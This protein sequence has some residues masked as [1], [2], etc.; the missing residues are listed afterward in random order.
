MFT[1]KS[2][3]FLVTSALLLSSGTASAESFRTSN[4]DVQAGNVRITVDRAGNAAV[5]SGRVN[6]YGQITPKQRW[7]PK[8]P[9][10]RYPAPYRAN[11]SSQRCTQESYSYS[12]QSNGNSQTYRST[13]VC[14]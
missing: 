10:R 1:N 3:L 9:L 4:V 8:Y 12:S 5:G 13:S 6:S 7:T 14:R 2:I 11:S